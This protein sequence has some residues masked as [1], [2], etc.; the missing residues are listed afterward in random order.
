[1]FED[2][3]IRGNRALAGFQVAL[4][5][6]VCFALHDPSLFICV[7]LSLVNSIRGRTRRVYWSG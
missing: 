4:P 6:G 5:Y 7:M 1:L 3:A 2:A